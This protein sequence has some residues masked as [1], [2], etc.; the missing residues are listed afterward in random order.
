[1]TTTPRTL[2]LT[3]QVVLATA[4]MVGAWA[5]A[6]LW[7]IGAA[8][9]PA[10][11]TRSNLDGSASWPYQLGPVVALALIGLGGLR[12]TRSALRRRKAPQQTRAPRATPARRAEPLTPAQ[13]AEVRAQKRAQRRASGPST[14][15]KRFTLAALLLGAVAFLSGYV[16]EWM[17]EEPQGFASPG[18]FLSLATLAA[19]FVLG[20]WASNRLKKSRPADPLDPEGDA[21]PPLL[22]IWWPIT[23]MSTFFPVWMIYIAAISTMGEGSGFPTGIIVA[24]GV[25]GFIILPIVVSESIFQ[26]GARGLRGFW[27]AFRSTVWGQGL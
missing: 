19:S 1:M 25:F 21:R 20:V 3:V 2:W 12:L 9:N 13:R 22:L 6:A 27:R 14:G 4:L 18:L 7:L 26:F 11:L 17:G 10:A 24:I 16:M 8:V 15:V 23:V 5:L